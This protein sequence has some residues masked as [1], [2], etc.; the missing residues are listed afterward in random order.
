VAHNLLFS[1]QAF[2]KLFCHAVRQTANYVELL[3]FISGN[4]CVTNLSIE[5][6]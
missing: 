6:D 4:E 1:T 3:R 2:L 5:L